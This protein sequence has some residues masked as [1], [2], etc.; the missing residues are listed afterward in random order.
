MTRMLRNISIHL[1]IT[2][3]FCIPFCF[4]M[5]PG[6]SKIFPGI[7]PVTTGCVTL[8]CGMLIIGFLMDMTAKKII[9]HL[10]KEGQAWERS[11]IFNKAEKNYTR[12][13]RIFDTF[14]FRP[15]FSRN[16]TR[17]ISA[18]IA[19]FQLNTAV[20][21]PNFK[22]V[23]AVYLKM[24][25]D[26]VDVA[27]LWLKQIGK[28]ACVTSFEQEV[29]SV[30]AEKYYADTTLSALLTDIFL[31]LER[32]DFTAKKLYNQIQKE[33]A[34]ENRYSKKIEDIIGKADKSFEQANYFFLDDKTQEKT[35][36]IGT[37]LKSIIS[38]CVCFLKWFGAGFGSVLSLFVLSTGKGYA[39]L[40][41]CENTRFYLKAGL[42]SILS[43]WFVVFM[44]S[45]FSHLLKSG[46]MEKQT[47][48]IEIRIPKP[49]T[50]QVSA[51]LKQQYAD[52]YVERLK[53]KGVK[54]MVKKVVGGGKT[55]F[56][57]R[58]SEFVD[59]KSATAYG[60]KLKQQNIIDDFFV[61]NI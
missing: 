10:I 53:K 30:L 50:I 6:L 17:K 35:I 25:P 59:K 52:K 13:L 49:F 39:Y 46:T 15:F 60:Q 23:A 18:A 26:D 5:L 2:T 57:V 48:K 32:K 61:N 12:A 43:V 45:T 38:E 1:W 4:Y 34:F 58:V 16:T 7:N 40:K 22:P 28:S 42:L 54:A 56:V 3:L 37:L 8:G 11:G 36:G 29:I 33:L 20:E 47:V 31:G 19:K 51:Y 44:V 55:W 9:N 14:L 21:N 41:E 27:E 24:N